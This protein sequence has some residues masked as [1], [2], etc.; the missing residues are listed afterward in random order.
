LLRYLAESLSGSHCIPRFE[1]NGDVALACLSYL[2]L[3][4]FDSDISDEEIDQF[5]IGGGYVLHDYAQS[6]FLYHIRSSWRAVDD[7]SEPLAITTREFLGTR[8]NPAFQYLDSQLPPKSWL[9][10]LQSK[11][12]EEHRKLNIIAAHLGTCRV[13]DNNDGWYLL[14]KLIIES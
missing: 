2:C 7:V 4:Y 12:P 8:W 6:N 5:I 13:T 9:G 3:R 10:K 1:S 14:C 11:Y